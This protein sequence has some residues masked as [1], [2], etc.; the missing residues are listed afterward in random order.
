MPPTTLSRVLLNAECALLRALKSM[1]EASIRFPDHATQI[2]WAD[3][4]TAREPDAPRIAFFLDGKNYPVQEPSN[5][6]VQN[7]FYNDGNRSI[8]TPLKSGDID[9]TSPV[10]RAAV[11]R[12]IQL[13]VPDD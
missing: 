10:L 8:V 2:D 6:D 13:F 3:A 9:K 7:A 1:P 12:V 5:R 4:C 11:E